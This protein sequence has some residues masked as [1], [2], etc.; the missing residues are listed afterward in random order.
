MKE[1]IHIVILVIIFSPEKSWR[2][3]RPFKNVY[4]RTRRRRGIFLRSFSLYDFRLTTVF[5]IKLRCSNIRCARLFCFLLSAV[6]SHAYVLQWFPTIR[7]TPSPEMRRL[8]KIYY[9]IFS[10]QYNF[11]IAQLPLGWRQSQAPVVVT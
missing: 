5:V 1:T 3:R 2:F 9:R 4:F 7:N 10:R 11:P 8:S 6:Q